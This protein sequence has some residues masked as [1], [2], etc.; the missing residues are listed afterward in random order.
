[1]HWH[2]RNT[3]PSQL[4]TELN[5]LPQSRRF[6]PMPTLPESTPSRP[7]PRA[8]SLAKIL[9]EKGTI[10]EKEYQILDR[11]GR[12]WC[13]ATPVHL[14]AFVL[15][16]V[17]ENRKVA[18]NDRQVVRR[19][20]SPGHE[21]RFWLIVA[22]IHLVALTLAANVAGI[23]GAV[24]IVVLE[25]V[26]WHR[27][28]LINA[29][30]VMR[31]KGW[32]K[33]ILVSMGLFLAV[34]TVALLCAAVFML[35]IPTSA[36]RQ[37]A[38]NANQLKEILAER[39]KAR[40][41]WVR[42]IEEQKIEGDGLKEILAERQKAI[43]DIERGE[44]VPVPTYRVV[45]RQTYDV[46]LKTQIQLHAIV[47]GTLTESGL[48]QLLLELF[49]K[50]NAMRGFKYHEGR[51][52]HVGIYVYT[53]ED[54][55]K[56]DSGQWIAMLVKNGEGAPL[57]T[58]VK[59][60]LIAQLDAKPEAKYD[61]SEASRR[62]VYLESIRADDRAHAEAERLIPLDGLNGQAQR[63]AWRKQ[64]V[65]I[66]ELWENFNAEIAKKY[67]ITNEQLLDICREAQAK[68][69]PLPPLP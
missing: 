64:G 50:A 30:R 39:Q 53:S 36:E 69:W 66:D 27:Q 20:M 31:L 61:L 48:R 16:I 55:F 14:M 43:L 32:D 57:E 60:E 6:A 8:K 21:A 67:G 19:L 1:M 44:G 45:D 26:V 46:P 3:G 18:E 5:H 58:R 47:S 33:P 23:G 63:Q 35:L 54:H 25:L 22:V 10:S 24:A 37:L 49:I 15:R 11:I 38:E 41:E 2:N 59:A 62:E 65:L 17:T 9:V 12:F 4:P 68:N 34:G 56:S 52:T 28:A 40:E 42:Q 13:L 51:P 7:A 29:L